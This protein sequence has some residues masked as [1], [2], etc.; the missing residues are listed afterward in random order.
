MK[1]KTYLI[2]GGAGFLGSNLCRYLIEKGHEVRSMDIADFDYPNLKEKVKVYKA[3]IRNIPVL[4]KAMKGC[5]A[6]IHCAAALPLW[7]KKEIYHSNFYGTKDVLETAYH[8][9]I[10]RVVHISTT[11]VY[12]IPEHHP[13]YETDKMDGVG[14][15]GKTKVM[16]EK[17]CK[18]YKNKGM[19]IP[20]LRP[21]SFTGPGRL[22]VFAILNDWIMRGKSVPIVGKGKNRYQLLDVEDL[23]EMIYLCLTNPK[24]VVNDVFNVGAKEFTTMKEDFGAV[25]TYAGFGKRIITT[26]AKPIIWTLR[27]LEFLGLSPLYKWI[28]ETAPE[29][30]FVSIEKAEK[31]L[32]FKPKF[33]NKQTLIR[34]YIW[35]VEHNK[36]Y[37]KTGV[38]HRT[39]WKQGILGFFRRF[40]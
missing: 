3:D 21:K 10:E 40:F 24:N 17:L 35:Y 8:L 33:S 12:G 13:L 4:R 26:P 32:G 31:K 5:D 29:D 36:E 14:P 30:S 27:F 19:C 25:L 1:K 38:T 2:T 9:K 22:G 39:P 16:A 7:P 37:K 34:T 6:V 18:E 11:A 15:Y 23:N 28:Y 20:I